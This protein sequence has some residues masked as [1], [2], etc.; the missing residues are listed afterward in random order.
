[1]MNRFIQLILQIENKTEKYI[2]GASNTKFSTNEIQNISLE[3]IECYFIALKI[4]D[5]NFKEK[6]ITSLLTCFYEEHKIEIFLFP[7]AAL[8]KSVYLIVKNAHNQPDFRLSGFELSKYYNFEKREPLR[9]YK[10]VRNAVRRGT[11]KYV[12][13]LKLLSEYNGEPIYD[14]LIKYHYPES[15]VNHVLSLGS[16]RFIK[17]F[18]RGLP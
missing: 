8:I 7:L 6:D 11:I 2:G 10:I 9:L 5:F 16:T 13:L 14:F 3:K 1:M 15:E 12:P 4:I 17:L 18:T